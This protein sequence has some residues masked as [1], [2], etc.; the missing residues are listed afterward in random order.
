MIDGEK[1]QNVK[2]RKS[3]H[4]FVEEL[5]RLEEGRRKAED[6]LWHTDKL[7]SS[8]LERSP[9]PITIIDPDGSI[10]YINQ[11]LEHLTGF[12][13]SE[14]IGQKPP[15]SWWIDAEVQSTILK[16]L[17]TTG[18]DGIEGTFR[19]KSGETFWVEITSTPIEVNGELQYYLS[20]WVDITERKQSKMVLTESE[21]EDAVISDGYLMINFTK[22]R[23]TA[24][25]RELPL[26]A[27]EYNLLTQLVQNAN[28]PLE[29]EY[30]LKKV[31]GPAYSSEKEY[32]YVYI[33]QLRRK[34]E[35]N[36]KKPRYIITERGVGYRFK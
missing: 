16:Q 4:S 5:E 21:R 24:G 36:P 15:Y 2:K 33:G 18:A 3:L 11:A 14:L 30:L 31:W 17:I 22:R 26:T 23:V 34:L 13:A 19:K 8:L 20:N 7:I 6:A 35:P 25:G 27:T 12:S 32:L 28:T 29:Y 9:I 10:R 1:G